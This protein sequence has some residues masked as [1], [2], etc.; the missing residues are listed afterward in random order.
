MAVAKPK[1]ERVAAI[2]RDLLDRGV[3]VPGA[4]S[5]S[6]LTDPIV[7]THS[8]LRAIHEIYNDL[9]DTN[10]SNDGRLKML[11]EKLL[12]A[13]L[14]ALHRLATMLGVPDTQ[15][16]QVVAITT[17]PTSP[18]VGLPANGGALPIQQPEMP[19]AP[20]AFSGSRATPK[21]QPRK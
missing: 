18:V 10:I 1:A 19:P 20:Q 7:S 8:R 12:D 11:K 5:V 14:S 16:S 4:S 13:R 3:A 2:Q 6:S 9:S 17:V 15:S 21:P